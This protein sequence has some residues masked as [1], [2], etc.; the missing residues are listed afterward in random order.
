MVRTMQSAERMWNGV[1]HGVCREDVEWSRPRGLRIGGGIVTTMQFAERRWNGDD[2]AVCREDVEWCTQAHLLQN[3][4]CLSF[5][6]KY[7]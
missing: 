6:Q 2:H 1:D 5:L 4:E 7:F 3:L